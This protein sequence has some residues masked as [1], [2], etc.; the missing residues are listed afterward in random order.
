MMAK[1]MGFVGDDCMNWMGMGL[2]LYRKTPGLG[3]NGHIN[4]RFQNWDTVRPGNWVHATCMKALH[5]V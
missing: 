4:G 5:L 3:V 1:L 2:V